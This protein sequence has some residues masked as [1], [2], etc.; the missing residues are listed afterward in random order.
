MRDFRSLPQP[1]LDRLGADPVPGVDIVRT[2]R[3]RDAR[4]EERLGRFEVR[5]A[6]DGSPIV[7]GYASSSEVWYDVYGGPE[8]GGW[9]ERIAR[10]AYQPAIDRGDDVRL[11]VNHGGLPLAR[12][13][14]GTL[15]LSEDAIGLHS[16]TPRGIDM[17]NPAAQELVSVMRRGDA[18]Q[19]S[20]AFQIARDGDE[21]NRDYTERTIGEFAGLFDVSVVTYPANPATGAVVRSDEPALVEAAPS[22]RPLVLARALI[23][24]HRSFSA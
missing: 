11:L 17:S 23:D 13:T 22:G 2:F 7:E 16:V 6:E 8:F 3:G 12:T 14:S 1:V 24:A 18:D 19:M 21:W 10:G 9:R 4:M 20:F 15:E 5:V